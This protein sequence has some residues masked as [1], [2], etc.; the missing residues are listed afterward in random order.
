M[1]PDQ[2]PPA[3]PRRERPLVA[4]GR[5]ST[6]APPSPPT[7]TSPP[8]GSRVFE[9]PIDMT[10]TERQDHVDVAFPGPVEQ[11][12]WTIAIRVIL[13]VPHFV[14]SYILNIGM[15]FAVLIAWFA[16]LFTKRVPDEV[17]SFIGKVNRY[18]LRLMA[19]GLLLT[20]EFPPFG[21]N[22]DHGVDLNVNPGEFNRA[23]VFFRWFLMVPSGI[24]SSLAM[25]GL[26]IV[27]VVSWLLALILGRLPQPLWEAHAAVV[28][29]TARAQAF[30][31]LLTA[32][33]PGGLFGDKESTSVPP[34][35]DAPGDLPDLPVRP[36][37]VRL[38]LSQA[39]KRL[40]ALFL[41]L[42][43]LMYVGGFVTLIVVGT[44]VSA[45][46]NKLDD[47]HSELI[48]DVGVYGASVQQC[49]FSGGPQCLSAANTALADSFGDFAAE[50]AAIKFPVNT[51]P[52]D[53]IDLAHQCEVALRAMAAATDQSSYNEAA[54]RYQRVV[55]EFDDEYEAF[56][57]GLEVD[58]S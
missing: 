16:A 23:A 26:F 28:R 13:M 53:V 3:R 1:A 44:K 32:E 20:D 48:A 57:V 31:N 54:A 52:V 25:F 18:Q 11:R 24:V 37:L 36:R 4:A 17:A 42:S 51:G 22:D 8:T 43:A 33:Q 58:D 46:Y 39:A 40:V 47:S 34:M 6:D 38:V 50:V 21:L 41:A 45:A 14:W 19:Y 10:V 29:Y 7:V 27:S 15:G 56:A 30:G 2:D 9:P 49:A 35:P 55:Q 12:R 5:E